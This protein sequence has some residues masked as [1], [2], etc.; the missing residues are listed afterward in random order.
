[1]VVVARLGKSEKGA[2]TATDK[3]AAVKFSG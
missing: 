3:G 2:D 1:V